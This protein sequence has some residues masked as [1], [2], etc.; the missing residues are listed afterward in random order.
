M[1]GEWGRA[2]RAIKELKIKIRERFE[3]VFDKNRK[4]LLWVCERLF[5]SCCYEWFCLLVSELT[6]RQIHSYQH[7][8]GSHTQRT[9]NHRYAQKPFFD[10]LKRL[11]GFGGGEMFERFAG[12]D[13]FLSNNPQTQIKPN[14]NPL[15]PSQTLSNP[16]PPLKPNSNKI[17]TFSRTP[18]NLLKPTSPLSN[19]K[20]ISHFNCYS[21]YFL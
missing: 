20:I 9:I 15:K 16:F 21:E 18:S 11:N 17:Q 3:G 1:G 4:N 12:V 10:T 13:G 19:P 7:P 5:A 14:S 2:L 6:I 8:T